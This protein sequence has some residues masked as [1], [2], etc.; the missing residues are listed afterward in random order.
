M[1][2]LTNNTTNVLYIKLPTP[3]HRALKVLA[4]QE[5]STLA[6]LVTEAIG[7]LVAQRKDT[8]RNASR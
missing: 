3:T 1:S 8:E 2:A 5:D 7:M 4:A 6:T